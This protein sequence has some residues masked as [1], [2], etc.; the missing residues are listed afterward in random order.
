MSGLCL[1][2]LLGQKLALGIEFHPCGRL[3]RLLKCQINAAGFYLIRCRLDR[4]VGV[5]IPTGESIGIGVQ[6]QLA[7][8]L[9]ITA[10]KSTSK[11]D[12]SAGLDRQSAFA[13]QS[14]AI[15]KRYVNAGF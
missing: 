4:T 12:V 13:C 11:S 10:A 6:S 5:K 3:D 1:Q 7:A 9:S 14:L 8:G 15:R 2:R